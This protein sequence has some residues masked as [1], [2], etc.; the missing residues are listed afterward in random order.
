MLIKRWSK[1]FCPNQTTGLE[2]KHGL[3]LSSLGISNTRKHLGVTKKIYD[4]FTLLIR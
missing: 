3:E 2:H 4:I 1:Y